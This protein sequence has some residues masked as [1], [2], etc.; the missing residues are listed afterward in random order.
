MSLDEDDDANVIQMYNQKVFNFCGGIK[1]ISNQIS[2][3]V[4]NNNYST[5]HFNET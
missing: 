2:N 5:T 3:G 4:C 1:M